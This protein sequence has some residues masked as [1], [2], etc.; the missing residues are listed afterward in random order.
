[1]P[2][3][4]FTQPP[5][6][7]WCTMFWHSLRLVCSSAVQKHCRHSEASSRGS[8]SSLTRSYS[9]R[10]AAKPFS[11]WF[12]RDCSLDSKTARETLLVSLQAAI[13]CAGVLWGL[14]V[15]VVVAPLRAFRCPTPPFSY[16]NLVRMGCDLT[17]NNANRWGVRSWL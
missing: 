12:T 5:R 3:K 1:M 6:C 11:S 13:Q 16:V 4:T 2:H 17:L 10:A 15:V 8:F 14:D 9:S 7:L